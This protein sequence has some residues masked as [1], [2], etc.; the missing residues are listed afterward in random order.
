MCFENINLEVFFKLV[1]DYIS[2][3]ENNGKVVD[4][5]KPN[6]LSQKISFEIPDEGQEFQEFLQSVKSYFAQSVKTS[7][8]QFLNQLYQGFNLPAFLGD[9]VTPASN[10]YI[11]TY[12]VAAVATHIERELIN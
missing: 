4:F 3:P 12:E 2:H 6:E 10:T 9:V 1:D 5:I 8:K 7:N 11:Y